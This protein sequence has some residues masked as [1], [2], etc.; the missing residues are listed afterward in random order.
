M[1]DTWIAFSLVGLWILFL[2]LGNSEIVSLVVY[3]VAGWQIGGWS[4]E[5][6]RRIGYKI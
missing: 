1:K 2:L 6:A 3:L 5:I 4:C